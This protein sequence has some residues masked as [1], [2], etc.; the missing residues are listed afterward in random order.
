MA[1][2]DAIWNKWMRVSNW[3]DLVLHEFDAQYQWGTSNIPGEPE[4]TGPNPNQL[5]PSLRALYAKFIDERLKAIEGKAASWT[6]DVQKNYD[7]NKN[8]NQA[9][10]HKQYMADAWSPQTGFVSSDKLRF[11]RPASLPA[12][13]SEFGA[14]GY[15][16]MTF[17]AGG[18]PLV[19]YIGPP[20]QL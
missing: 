9:A 6:A 4:R 1:N 17:D 3:I 19:T 15:E 12:G 7:K 18:N 20:P 13:I 11:P 5:K 2:E 16:K 10:D 8:W 14:W